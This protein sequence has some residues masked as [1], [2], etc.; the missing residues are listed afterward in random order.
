MATYK[1]SELMSRLSEMLQDGFYFTYIFEIDADDDSPECLSFEAVGEDYGIDYEEVES[2]DPDDT[3]TSLTADDVS[4]TLIF[5]FEELCTLMNAVDNA[6]EYGK[7][8][9]KQP[10][11]DREETDI[12]KQN[13]VELRN[14][15][16]KFAKFRKAHGIS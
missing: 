15:Q 4:A 3:D 12:I 6:L 9:L 8:R 14:M 16:A 2:V 11:C 13:S 1:I 7:H 10:D 5:S